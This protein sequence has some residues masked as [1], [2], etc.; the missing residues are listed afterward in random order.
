MPESLKGILIALVSVILAIVMAVLLNYIFDEPFEVGG[1]VTLGGIFGALYGLEAGLLLSYDLNVWK[2][3][4][5]LVIDLTWSLPNTVFGFVFGNLIY[6][7]FGNPS[8]DA[9]KDV[10]WVAFLPRSADHTG[11]GYDVLQTLG[12]VNLGGAGQHELMHVMQA[13]IFGPLYLP[14]FALNYVVNFLI[15][16][17]WTITIGLALWKAKV[18]DT[19]YFRPPEESAVSGF[20]GWIY[21]A[22]LFEQWAYTSGNP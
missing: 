17:L 20:F 19:P 18:R 13:R 15:Q 3:W 7:F 5:Q 1:A 2:G 9:S 12:T 16:G 4:L 10:G 22:T 8:R 6:I 11:F 14:L 21:Y